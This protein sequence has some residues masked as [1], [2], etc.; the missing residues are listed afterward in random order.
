MLTVLQTL[1]QYLADPIASEL[2]RPVPVAPNQTRAPI[3]G[4]PVHARLVTAIALPPGD[5]RTIQAEVDLPPI[6]DGH[7]ALVAPCPDLSVRGVF[8]AGMVEPVSVDAAV[9]N[10]VRIT[11]VNRN[12]SSRG[13]LDAYVLIDPGDRVA[14]ILI[15]SHAQAHAAASAAP[16]H[17]TLIRSPDTGNPTV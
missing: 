4:H 10:P 7:V 14:Q 6:P 8:P 17:P 15:V 5:T 1:Q 12:R 2:A 16:D 11:L 9:A 13:P 3:P